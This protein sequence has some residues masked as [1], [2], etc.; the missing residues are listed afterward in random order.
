MG[1]LT[2][3]GLTSYGTQQATAPLKSHMLVIVLNTPLD[4]LRK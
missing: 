1:I 4:L 3:N 2:R